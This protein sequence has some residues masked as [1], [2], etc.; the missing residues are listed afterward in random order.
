M[1][2]RIRLNVLCAPKKSCYL[3]DRLDL[4]LDLLLVEGAE[5]AGADG[6]A[7]KAGADPKAEGAAAVPKGA[8]ATAPNAGAG[9]APNSPPPPAGA[10]AVA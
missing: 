1:A 7:P 4:D 9:A 10:A 6:A 8:A 2:C 5:A 3:L